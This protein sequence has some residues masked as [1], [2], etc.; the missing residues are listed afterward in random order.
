MVAVEAEQVQGQS[1]Q[2]GQH[3]STGAAIAMAILIGLGIANPVPAFN[4]P[5]VPHQLQQ[6]F[7]RCAQAGEK[8]VSLEGGLAVTLSADHQLDDPTAAGPVLGDEGR[9]LFGP[10]VPGGVAAVT[11]LSETAAVKGILRE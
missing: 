9:S 11:V 8:Q 6:G 5:A 4:A 10:E 2:R 3:G 7:C 1:A